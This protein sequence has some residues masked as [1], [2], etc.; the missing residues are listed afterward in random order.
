MYPWLEYLQAHIGEKEIVGSDSNP[1]IVA[2]FKHTTYEADSDETPWCAAAACAALEESGYL[3]PH[4]AA[5]KSFETYGEVCELKV[6]AVVVMRRKDGGRHVTFCNSI[7]DE[8][9]FVGLGGNQAD[10]IKNSVFLKENI[11]AIRWPVTKE[12]L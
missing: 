6:G 12:S 5:A 4:N 11:V 7:M 3:S 2:L 8:T 10:R 9:R 1:F